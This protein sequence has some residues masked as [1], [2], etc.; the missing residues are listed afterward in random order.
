MHNQYLRNIQRAKEYLDLIT[1]ERGNKYPITHSDLYVVPNTH[2]VNTDPT[3][4]VSADIDCLIFDQLDPPDLLRI[5]AVCKSFFQNLV[6]RSK[7]PIINRIQIDFKIACELNSLWMAQWIIRDHKD[8][9]IANAIKKS[10]EYTLYD[11]NGSIYIYLPFGECIHIQHTPPDPEKYIVD[12]LNEHYVEYCLMQILPMTKHAVAEFV[13]KNNCLDIIKWIIQE[14][15][16]NS[17]FHDKYD[18]LAYSNSTEIIFNACTTGNTDIVDYVIGFFE[19]KSDTIVHFNHV[20]DYVFTKLVDHRMP[21]EMIQYLFC[22]YHQR[23]PVSQRFLQDQFVSHPEEFRIIKWCIETAADLKMPI[24]IHAQNDYV[25]RH[26]CKY[27]KLT[28]TKYLYELSMNP[29][30]GSIDFGNNFVRDVFVAAWQY[31]CV[32]MVQWLLEITMH[33]HVEMNF[34]NYYWLLFSIVCKRINFN[35]ELAQIILSLHNKFNNCNNTQYIQYVQSI[36][37]AYDV[38]QFHYDPTDW[39]IYI[40]STKCHEDRFDNWHINAVECIIEHAFKRHICVNEPR[41]SG[42][43]LLYVSPNPSNMLEYL[44]RLNKRFGFNYFADI[45]DSIM[46]LELIF[47]DKSHDIDTVRSLSQRLIEYAESNNIQICI[48]KN[49][50]RMINDFEI[51]KMIQQMPN[52]TYDLQFDQ[53]INLL[54]KSV[55]KSSDKSYIKFF[56]DMVTTYIDK[57]D[58]D[59]MITTEYVREVDLYHHIYSIK[60]FYDE[61]IEEWIKSLTD[62]YVR[63]RTDRNLYRIPLVVRAGVRVMETMGVVMSAPFRLL[64]ETLNY[65]RTK[66]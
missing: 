49:N 37:D 39:L 32:P 48:T 6:V 28:V 24:D 60:E 54:I 22:H 61:S 18:S 51:S 58:A 40:L 31:Q 10:I 66:N 46:L 63:H 55:Q 38:V 52:A 29:S 43:I 16:K 15:D 26:A 4:L 62:E 1:I 50:Y 8:S 35:T 25:F 30:Y 9:H 27:G 17:P 36:F 56:F 45:I 23:Y 47:F 41:M 57:Y 21:I 65:F 14:L 44:V 13:C 20:L 7:R 2:V 64:C 12:V 3:Y 11:P 42:I 19:S 33:M 5:S 59:N 53:T 34:P